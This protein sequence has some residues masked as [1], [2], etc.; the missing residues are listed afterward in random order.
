MAE[1]T[2][3]KTIEEQVRKQEAKLQTF[4]ES[5]S[6]A[7]KSM[8]EKML[9]NSTELKALIAG[10]FAQIGG[11]NRSP[12]QER[13]LLA[14]P[15]SSLQ[16]NSRQGQ[17]HQ[18]REERNAFI[19]GVPKLEFPRF[20]GEQV[21]DWIQKC[22]T[23]FHLYGILD[24]QKMLIAK[25]HLEGRANVWFQSFKKDKRIF[26]WEEFKEGVSRRFGDLGDEDGVEEFNKLQQSFTEELK[27]L[28]KMHKPQTHKKPSRL[29]DGRKRHWRPPVAK[30]ATVSEGDST[31]QG[32]VSQPYKRITP[33]EF[34]YRKDNHL[35]FKC[36][37][38]FGPGH[39]CKDKG[40]HMIIAT[41]L[42]DRIDEEEVIEY[43]GS[44]NK[45]EMEAVLIVSLGS[46]LHKGSRSL[47]GN[48]NLSRLELLMV[49]NFVAVSGYPIS[50]GACKDRNFATVSFSKDGDMATLRGDEGTANTRMTKGEVAKRHMRKKLKQAVQAYTVSTAQSQ[51]VFS[52]PKQ[53]PPKRSFDHQIP[54]KADAKPFKLAPY[55]YPYVQ[56]TE[57]EKQ[58][59]EMLHSGIIQPSHSLFASP[60]LLID[61]RSG[62]HQICMNPLDI[63]K[64]AFKTHCGLYEFLVMPFGFTN[65]PATF[66]ALMNSVFEPFLR[67]FVLV[68]FDDI[69]VY[70]LDM[71]SHILHLRQVLETLRS[72]T[73]FAKLTKC[74]F[75]QNQIEYLGHVVTGEGVSADPS[76][77]E[78][79]VN[80]LEP[81]DVKALR[82][83]LGLT[84]YYKRF[85][86]N[87]G[88]IAKP[89]TDLLKEDGFVWNKE[90]NA[91]NQAIGAVIMQQGQPIAY[92]SQTLGARNQALSI[93]EKELLALIAA[94]NKWRH[95]VLGSHFIIRT[96]HHSL[97]YLLEQKIWTPLQQKWLTKLMGYDYETQFKM[98]RENVVADALS[99]KGEDPH[100]LSAISMVKPAWIN[101]LAERYEQDPK[102]KELLTALAIND[103]ERLEYSYNGGVIRYKGRIYVGDS[104]S[105]RQQLIACMHMSAVGGHSGNLGTYKR[106]KAY[107][108]WPGMKREV[109]DFVQS[110]D[111]CKR[112][113]GENCK[114]PGLL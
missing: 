25:M 53:L 94:V 7:L 101:N 98:G 92:M 108:F 113:K 97:K 13:G 20:T 107:F 26:G 81:T 52:E 19:P 42:E 27:A 23:F 86:K 36:G 105:L 87:Y 12:Q 3:L 28:V 4:M 91:S 114:P 35:C 45:Q 37:A 66:Q 73:F 64:T 24:S 41:D 51:D 70:S 56:K 68:F 47:S 95:Y 2:R 55:R 72:H 34:Q 62:Y 109:E 39:M 112:K 65:A 21:R 15:T 14:T 5:T 104:T 61:L 89:L 29:Q 43:M 88:S 8:E 46:L 96:D 82:G 90:A 93:Y 74:S 83:F 38:K 103:T 30:V 59:N 75:G 17:G 84:G 49:R 77:V 48:T 50:N 16:G 110:Y 54:L 80:W 31:K 79:M 9:A 85:V 71:N 111:I 99:R 44:G 22:E 106:A 10:I 58:V 40:V 18:E 67:K 1:G 57:I 60:V 78:C 76:K 69:L 100:E 102:A 32:N 63:P 11:N 6:E 33:T